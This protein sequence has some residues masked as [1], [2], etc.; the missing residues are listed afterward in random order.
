L[1]RVELHGKARECR[2]P[3][4]DDEASSDQQ[5]EQVTAA[6]RFHCTS[7][8]RPGC[9]PASTSKRRRRF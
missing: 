7:K 5:A 1:C 3:L 2:D 4:S 9:G 8:R 6:V